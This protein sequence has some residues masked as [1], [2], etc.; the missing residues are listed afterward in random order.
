MELHLYY[1]KLLLQQTERY[2][3][4]EYFLCC[5]WLLNLFKVGVISHNIKKIPEK[6]VWRTTFQMLKTLITLA[7]LVCY[8]EVNSIR[9]L[10]HLDTG[11][12]ANRVG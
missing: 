4:F 8:A 7:G 1:S 10:P 6:Q 12:P 9:V 11:I 5:G 3:R 2:H